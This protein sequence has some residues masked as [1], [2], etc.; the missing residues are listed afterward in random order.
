LTDWLKKQ[1]VY[2]HKL[3][4][5]IFTSIRAFIFSLPGTCLAGLLANV[6]QYIQCTA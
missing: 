4:Y 6:Q 2:L 1:I 5:N 3:I